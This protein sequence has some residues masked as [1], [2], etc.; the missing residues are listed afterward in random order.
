[1]GVLNRQR[2]NFFMKKY[3]DKIETIK[4]ELSA[5]TKDITDK[6]SL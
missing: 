2:C 4:K 6:I 1:M 3:V 5:T